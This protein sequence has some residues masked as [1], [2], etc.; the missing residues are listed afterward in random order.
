MGEVIDG[1]ELVDPTRP[2]YFNGRG[3]IPDDDVLAMIRNVIPASY[4][5]S[6]VRAGTASPIAVV[7]DQ[8]VTIG[9]VVGGATVVGIDRNGVTLSINDE[10]RRITMYGTN[11]KAPAAQQ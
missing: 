7:N 1:E 2:I 9:D 5:V 10:E 6:F 8:R 3:N 4:E 11:V